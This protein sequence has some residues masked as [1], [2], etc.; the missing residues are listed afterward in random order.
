MLKSIAGQIEM[1]LGQPEIEFL[2][3]EYFGVAQTGRRSIPGL[4][5]FFYGNETSPPTFQSGQK[6]SDL[7][8]QALKLIWPSWVYIDAPGD[9]LSFTGNTEVLTSYTM[10]VY[11]YMADCDFLIWTLLISHNIGDI[12]FDSIPNNVRMSLFR[13]SASMNTLLLYKI[14]ENGNFMQSLLPSISGQGWH[15][16]AFVYNDVSKILTAYADGTY[17]SSV[18]NFTKACCGSGAYVLASF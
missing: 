17:F 12:A 2:S 8:G 14:D 11:M 9:E 10:G 3:T 6:N 5:V 4:K 7:F 16:W 18:A 13:V 15:H 1:S